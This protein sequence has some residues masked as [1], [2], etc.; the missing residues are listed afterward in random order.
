[1][2]TLNE[3]SKQA[4]ALYDSFLAEQND[5]LDAHTDDLINE[6][7]EFDNEGYGPATHWDEQAYSNYRYATDEDG[8][9]LHPYDIEY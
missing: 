2:K 5:F 1:M 8:N 7:P 4:K 6:E 9:W 3:L